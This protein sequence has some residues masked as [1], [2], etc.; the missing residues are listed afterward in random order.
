M[1]RG[2]GRIGRLVVGSPRIGARSKGTKSL[3]RA[4]YFLQ[5]CTVTHILIRFQIIENTTGPC[6]LPMHHRPAAYRVKCFRTPVWNW[7]PVVRRLNMLGIYRNF[8][9][10]VPILLHPYLQCLEHRSGA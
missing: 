10:P 5:K 4:R 9:T 1:E 8:L 6:T 7:P 2:E 3:G